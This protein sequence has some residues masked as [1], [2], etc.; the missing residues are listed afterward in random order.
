MK[1]I[2]ITAL[3]APE[4]S[5]STAQA[6]MAT[7]RAYGLESGGHFWADDLKAMAWLGPLESLSE[8]DT[9]A[10]VI[11]GSRKSLEPASVRYGLGL[12]ALSVQAKKGLGFPILFLDSA[13][14][15]E[16]SALP[17]PL[18]GAYVFPAG[19][20]GIGAKLAAR[21]NLPLKPF[22][23]GYRVNI[24]A[25]EHFGVWFEIGPSGDATW[26]GALL[27]TAGGLIDFHGAGPA[28][29]LPQKAVLEYPMQG[30]TL[31]LRGREY[32]AWAVQNK[33]DRGSSY[34]VRVR[35]IP[36]GIV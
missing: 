24:H 1:K 7:V 5:G 2:W 9:A 19:L 29:S 16:L 35:D 10:W 34:Y 6:L 33:L 11:L 4:Q 28:G 13:E 32:T 21:A 36:S 20:S 17:F 23:P 22:D 15:L 3:D 14:G 8:R 18:R 26:S 25:S 27:G 31:E 30:L 12:L